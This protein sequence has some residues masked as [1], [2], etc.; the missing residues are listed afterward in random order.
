MAWLAAEKTPLPCHRGEGGTIWLGGR[1][2]VGVPAH[3]YVH[4]LI[5]KFTYIYISTYTIYIIYIYTLYN[6]DAISISFFRSRLARRATGSASERRG[7]EPVTAR[8]QLGLE[9]SGF[10]IAGELLGKCWVYYGL[11]F[12]F[13]MEH[14]GNDILWDKVHQHW[15]LGCIWK[16]RVFSQLA[17]FIR[18]PIDFNLKQPS[19]WFET[20]G[21]TSIWLI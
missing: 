6:I 12:F 8:R 18:K 4:T 5:I 1:G 7:A 16:C 13:L 20:H 21:D 17:I 14:D 10:G 15:Y 3:I 9:G 2:G 11:M 19:C